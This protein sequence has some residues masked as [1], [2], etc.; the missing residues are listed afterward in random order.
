MKTIEMNNDKFGAWDLQIVDVS[1][2]YLAELF[3]RRPH[4][5][6]RDPTKNV[7]TAIGLIQKINQYPRTLNEQNGETR[8]YSAVLSFNFIEKNASWKN[9]E[10]VVDEIPFSD[11]SKITFHDQ[12]GT[13]IICLI[14][15]CKLS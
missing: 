2:Y 5:L 6:K 10:Q 9:V 11:I 13:P 3:F 12:Q 1:R 7:S 4:L 8:S 14:N 15:N